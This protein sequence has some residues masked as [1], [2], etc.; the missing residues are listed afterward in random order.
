MFVN[1]RLMPVRICPKDSEKSKMNTELP[2]FIFV[3]Q[4]GCPACEMFKPEFEK[5]ALK[6]KGKVNFVK[7]T[8]ELGKQVPPPFA[9]YCTWYPSLL[10]CSPT[11]YFAIF[12]T[13]NKPRPSFDE[14]MT[15]R[16]EKYASVYD[17]G[18]FHYTHLPHTSDRVVKW[19]LRVLPKVQ[20]KKVRFEDSK[21]KK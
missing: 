2:V 15:I 3:A 18:S 16:C 9:K 5:V 11:S 10:L 4:T 6:L 8:L 7:F 19:A 17:D 12:D 13:N 14:K 1:T 20:K 21:T